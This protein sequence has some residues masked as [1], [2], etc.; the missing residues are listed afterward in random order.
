MALCISECDE[1]VAVFPKF[2]KLALKLTKKPLPHTGF[3]NEDNFLYNVFATL[4]DWKLVVAENAT[5]WDLL[6]PM[7][8]FEMNAVMQRII[9]KLANKHGLDKSRIQLPKIL[10]SA[11]HPLPEPSHRN[12]VRLKFKY[13]LQIVQSSDHAVVWLLWPV[14]SFGIF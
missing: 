12:K 2:S 8:Q 6:E 10:E 4:S 14:G 7:A 1:R 9:E 3:T 13:T 11:S 5:L